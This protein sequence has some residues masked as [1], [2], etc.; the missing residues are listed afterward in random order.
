MEIIDYPIE[1]D[2]IFDTLKKSGIKPILVGGYIRDKLLNKKSKDIDIELYGVSSLAKV[3]KILQKFGDVNSVGKSFGVC[4]IV[5][6]GYDLDFSLPR[7][8]NKI[9]S[10]HRGFDVEIDSNLDFKTAASRRDFT[11]NAIGYDIIEKKIVD[12]FNGKE[13]LKNRI[14]RAVNLDSFGQDPLRVLRAAQFCARFN[15]QIEYNLYLTCKDMVSKHLLDELPKER[16]FEEIK[17]LLLKSQKPS[18]GFKLLKEFGFDFFTENMF[19]TDI[20]AKKLTTNKQTNLVLM[21][22]ALCYNFKQKETELFLTK[23]TN[24][25]KLFQRVV[26]LIETHKKLNDLNDDYALYKLAVL[27]NI[28]EL[29]ILSSS[30]YT[31]K[32]NSEMVKKCEDIYKRA[33]EL[34]IIDKKLPPLLMGRDILKLELHP[35]ANFSQILNDAYE[36]QMHGKFKNHD[37]ASIWL[38][39]YLK[40]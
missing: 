2:I 40:L 1:I 22:A 18:R 24:E 19:I 37:E 31:L 9:K 21:L 26:A 14:L 10:G 16:V 15:F 13:D 36:A 5:F 25:K 39:E 29:L 27:T 11:I 23:L 33:K 20:V 7:K 17:K 6:K 30:I 35:S 4:K 32:G 12:P 3:E 28:G 34:G 38:K 8:D